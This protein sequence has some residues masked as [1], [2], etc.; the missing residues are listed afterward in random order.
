MPTQELALSMPTRVQELVKMRDDGWKCLE[1]VIISIGGKAGDIRVV[2]A[3]VHELIKI[4]V[5]KSRIA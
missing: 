4:S 5:E 1:K 3:V 2:K